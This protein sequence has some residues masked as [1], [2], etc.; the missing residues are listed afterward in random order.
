MFQGCSGVT[1]EIPELPDGLTD[2]SYMFQAMGL[3]GSSIPLLPSSLINGYEMFSEN[4]NLSGYCT[5]RPDS[6]TNYENMYRDTRV[7]CDYGK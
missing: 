2:G 7:T 6:L 1:G 3:N 5:G 4:Y